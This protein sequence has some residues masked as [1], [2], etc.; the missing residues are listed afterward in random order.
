M[1]QKEKMLGLSN[2][3]FYQTVL[4]KPSAARGVTKRLYEEK[5]LN[6]LLT[7][8]CCITV[9]KGLPIALLSSPLIPLV[10][11]VKCYKK[12]KKKLWKLNCITCTE[13]KTVVVHS[14]IVYL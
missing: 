2:F 13:L 5:V 4:K 14:A 6:R 7:C 9:Q 3:S 10:F 8:C 11:N 1:W 12:K